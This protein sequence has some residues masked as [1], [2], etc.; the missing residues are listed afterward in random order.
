[1]DD[2]I[3][4]S[5]ADRDRVTTRLRDYY[6]EGRLTSDELDERI[7]AALSAKTFGELRQVMKDLPQSPVT[8]PPQTQ[9]RRTQSRPPWFARRRR[10]RLLPLVLLLVLAVLLIPG[11]GWLFSLLF[12][13]ILVFWLVA[14]VAGLFVAARFRRRLRRAGQT[15]YWPSAWQGGYRHDWRSYRRW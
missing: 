1:M 2:R 12:K 4:I 10:P 6:A 3:R 7:T 13:L 5:D 15:G 8:P 11:A 9:Q 14:I